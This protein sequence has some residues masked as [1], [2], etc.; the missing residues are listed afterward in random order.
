MFLFCKLKKSDLD[1]FFLDKIFILNY[2]KWIIY[3]VAN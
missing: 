1:Q 2:K 3:R